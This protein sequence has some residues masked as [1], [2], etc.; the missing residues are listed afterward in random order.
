M[1]SHSPSPFLSLPHTRTRTHEHTRAHTHIMHAHTFSLYICLFPLLA[2][3][4]NMKENL[5][6]SYTS[7]RTYYFL[8]ISTSHL[9]MIMDHAEA[10]IGPGSIE[11]STHGPKPILHNHCLQHPSFTLRCCYVKL[12]WN[13]NSSLSP[14]SKQYQA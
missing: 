12:W 1:L 2:S 14:S 4:N 7:H 11:C 10:G 3:H 6:P 8:N 13:R 5:F 9:L